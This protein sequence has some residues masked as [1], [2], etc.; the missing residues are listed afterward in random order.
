MDLRALPPLR[1][2]RAVPW[3]W[4]LGLLALL[5]TVAPP[6]AAPVPESGI[7]V[8]VNERRGVYEDI[9]SRLERSGLAADET[10]T[11]LSL[12]DQAP[13]FERLGAS[14]AIITIGTRAAEAVY[15]AQATTPVLSALITESGFTYLAQTYYGSVDAALEKGVSAI[16]LD[17][18]LER[19]YRLGRLLLPESERIGVLTS[20]L[21]LPDSA[22][23]GSL[24]GEKGP[25]VD[26]V[27]VG[28]D[29]S[30]I[31]VLDP[32]MKRSDF[33][34]ATPGKKAVTVSAA[35]W[36]LRISS[37]TRTPVIAYSWKYVKSGALAA[38]FTSP[39]DVAS[40]VV[41]LM[42]AT[43]NLEL[44]P[45][46]VYPPGEFSVG[47]NRTVAGI[48]DIPFKDEAFYREEIKRTEA[49]P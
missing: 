25:V 10:L 45:A 19:L 43:E 17:Q 20:D 4:L 28:S 22:I 36:I 15:R 27:R 21:P 6:V 1:R 2:F 3:R 49:G 18:P 39:A 8:V 23:R 35:R 34:I 47:I 46:R 44:G 5:W 29:S 32:V 16:F 40:R 13:P 38:V 7:L 41:E 26:F 48:L 37:H 14:S 24:G 31:N 12:A 42:K 9:I 11:I 30:P 33:V